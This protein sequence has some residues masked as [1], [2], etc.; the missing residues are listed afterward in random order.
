MNN[1]FSKISPLS[2]TPKI[3]KLILILGAML[4]LAV[5]L[6]QCSKLPTEPEMLSENRTTAAEAQTITMS[7]TNSYEEGWQGSGAVYRIYMPGAWNG[8]LVVFAHGYVAPDEPI[9]I[10]EDQL[11]LPDGTSIPGM[12]NDLGY[13][14][15][16]SSFS[17]NGLAV[18]EGID[19]LVDLV[20]I[21]ITK[22]G[23]PGYTYL[24]GAS[25]GGLITTLSVE[26]Y[27]DIY[28]GGLATCGPIGDFRRQINYLGDFRVVFDY[29]FP[30]I[31][32]GSPVDVP[33]EVMDNWD[34]LYV[35]LIK[36]AISSNP[37]AANQLLKVTR[38]AT[39]PGD[40]TSIEETILG[41]LWYTAFAT[42]DAKDKLGG[43]PYD[44][45]KR[46]YFGSKNDLRLNLKVQ[47]FSA[48]P[49]AINE[50]EAHYQTSG[51]L[52]SPIVTLHTILDPIVPYWHERSYRWKVWAN[53]A[54]SM[55]I[56]I[57]II[58]YGHCDFK[59]NEVLAA[60]AVLVF[61]VKGQDLLAT[62]KVLPNDDERA[63]FLRLAQKYG[64]MQK[65]AI[66]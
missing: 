31:I 55:H 19:D 66:D 46:W 61:K 6:T 65:M 14:F 5:V 12:V 25:E 34:Q 58:R 23:Q 63:D 53:G 32:P 26:N 43:Q 7:A 27:P 38:A 22:H 45:K 44:N 52:T 54:G 42:N 64:A 40:A 48:D 3:F 11:E 60:F 29:F 37:D 36:Q 33:Q 10:P 8:D 1:L 18:R 51:A 39:D 59:V 9:A 21:F 50:I 20:S 49:A 35:P 15:A 2:A 13:A 17:K 57:P 47:R 30:G 56:N 4:L 41:V 28:N 16:V 24:V 62:E